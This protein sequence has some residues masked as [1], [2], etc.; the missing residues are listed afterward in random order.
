MN[1]FNFMITLSFLLIIFIIPN[2]FAETKLCLTDCQGTPVDNPRYVCEL[3]SKNSC[4]DPGICI[5][6]V[7]ESGNPTDLN[8]C[9]DQS[10]SILDDGGTDL[11]PPVLTIFSPESDFW[12]DDRRVPALLEVDSYSLLEYMNLADSRPRWRTLCDKCTSYDKDI[13]LNE[14]ENNVTFKATKKINGLT[15]EANVQFNID[16]KTPK[17]HRTYP[18]KG[19][20]A[21]GEFIV[22]YTE[23]NL[24]DIV[25]NYGTEGNMSDLL[26]DWCSSGSKQSCSAVVDLSDFDGQQIQYWFDVSDFVRTVS[27]RRPVEVLVD[28]TAPEILNFSV[29]N[30][31]RNVYFDVEIDDETAKIQYMDLDDTKPKWKTLC[32]MDLICERGKRFRDGEHNLIVRAIDKAE[33]TDERETTITIV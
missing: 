31:E 16:S 19:E 17:I 11:E 33:N 23:D 26:M 9:Q 6:C 24:K 13:R 25:L 14:G 4:G 8:R 18:K 21:N 32:S 22:E 20:Y 28:I 12:Y 30:E 27:N 5:V 29:W 3:G 15:D 7:T 1:K 10:C 2:V